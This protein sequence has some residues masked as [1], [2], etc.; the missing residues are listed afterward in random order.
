MTTI[1][2]PQFFAPVRSVKLGRFVTSVDHPH[3]DY[4]DP[5]YAHPPLASVNTSAHYGGITLKTRSSGFATALT[6][7]M[8][9]GFSKRA[10]TQ[11]RI[12][13]ERVQTHTLENSSEWFR[14]AAS[15]EAT[16]RWAERAIDQ[17]DDLYFVVSFTTVTDA[18]V[19]RKSMQAKEHTGQTGVPVGL[20]LNAAGV[21]APLGNLVD[22]QVGGQRGSEDG[23]AEHFLAPGEQICAVQ[24]RKVCHRWLSS[25]DIGQATLAKTPRWAAGDRWRDEE[26]GV[27]DILEVDTEAIGQ[28]EGGWEQLEGDGEVL[29]L[30]SL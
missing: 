3:Q 6:S 10:N 26:E 14:E 29:I 12:K 21:V 17:G 9:A 28:L 22:P 1:L 16:Q 4:H 24:Y 8:S 2:F 5:A 19:V 11:V 15:C 18:R 23:V 27:D 13:A 25:K 20:S 30:R 7:L